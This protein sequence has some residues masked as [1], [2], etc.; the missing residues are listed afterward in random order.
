MKFL[1]IKL[2][3]IELLF[4]VVKP[5]LDLEED[6]DET[7][8]ESY[9]NDDKWAKIFG[10][11][12]RSWVE[13]KGRPDHLK[14]RFVPIIQNEEDVSRSRISSLGKIIWQKIADIP[15]NFY[16]FSSTIIPSLYSYFIKHPLKKP[17]RPKIVYSPQYVCDIEIPEAPRREKATFLV[18]GGGKCT[19]CQEEVDNNMKIKTVGLAFVSVIS[20]GLSTMIIFLLRYIFLCC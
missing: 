18:E 17:E 5:N 2:Y 9:Y 13:Y 19:T 16:Q 7:I 6:D 10:R 8:E 11:P 20:I 4:H 14:H 15:S 1:I 3:L 12:D